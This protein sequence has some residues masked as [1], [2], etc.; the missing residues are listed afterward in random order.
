MRLQAT[1]AIFLALL[2][3]LAFG[4]WIYFGCCWYGWCYFYIEEWYL[5][6]T[7][8]KYYDRSTQNQ[9][10]VRSGMF[11]IAARFIDCLK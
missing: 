8:L 7:Y 1:T 5:L 11:C 4:Y 2:L 6:K 10:I 3:D 9:N